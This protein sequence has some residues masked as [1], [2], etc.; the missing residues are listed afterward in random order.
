LR[1]IQLSNGLLAGLEV[2]LAMRIYLNGKHTSG[3]LD[4]DNRLLRLFQTG[5]NGLFKSNFIKNLRND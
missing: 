1:T 4:S 3:K 2:S 5:S